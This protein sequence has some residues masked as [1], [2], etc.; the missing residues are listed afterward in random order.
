MQYITPNL[1]KDMIIQTSPAVAFEMIKGP[2]HMF[3]GDHHLRKSL[4]PHL[5]QGSD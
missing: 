3:E 5:Q 2:T 4:N 1:K